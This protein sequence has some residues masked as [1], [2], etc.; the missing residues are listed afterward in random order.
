[1]EVS[2]QLHVSVALPPGKSPLYTLAKKLG[3]PQG[4]SGRC[5]EENFLPMPGIESRFIGSLLS[6]KVSYPG[7][8]KL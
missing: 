5:G 1:M 2:G 3:G 4:R 6:R 8:L 7:S